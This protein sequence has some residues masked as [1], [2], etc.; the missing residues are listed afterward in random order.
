MLEI[1]MEPINVLILE[2]APA[3]GTPMEAGNLGTENGEDDV[4]EVEWLTHHVDEMMGKVDELERRVNEVAQFYSS[5]NKKLPNS[6]K[7]SSIVKDKDK[8]KLNP[9]IKK[10]QQ[11]ATQ[12]EAAA[13]KRMQELMR[14]F[15][16]ILRQITQHK[17]SWPFMEPVDVEGLGLPDY[18]EVIEKPMDFSTIKNQ[19]EAK[20]GSG[21]KN[22]REI[23][24]DVRL[25]FK[26]AMTYNEE[27]SDV[28][29]MAKTLLAKFE[30]KWLQL[31]PKVIEEETRRKEE[32][33]EAQL[34]MQLAQEAANAKLARDTSS[35]ICEV[36][37]HLEELREMVVQKCRKMSTE[38]KR[39]LGVGLSR[40]SPEDLNKALEIIAQKNP[41][42]LAT[43]EEVDLDMD[44]Q[45]ESTL[46]RLKF[47]VKE[48][49]EG[50]GKSSGSKGGNENSKRKREIC[51]ALAK[52]AKKRGKKLPS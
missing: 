5:S 25:V 16:T 24:T 44:A 46:W 18:Y 9:S 26:N 51:D 21:Y 40:L 10:Q 11:D 43:A 33:A 52:T 50:H 6:S 42:F 17:W 45:S 49:L 29:V 13:A 30:E 37:M 14:Q 20:D 12:R 35:E 38:E 47:F 48:A 36:D 1:P 2:R 19:M 28:H 39:K 27:K 32:E 23:C 22:V 31:L 34:G 15:S 4:A 3:D 8:E 7:G 41:S